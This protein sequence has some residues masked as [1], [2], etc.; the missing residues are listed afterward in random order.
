MHAH[1]WSPHPR[2]L[3]FL[4]S[5]KWLQALCSPLPRFLAALPVPVCW[6]LGACGGGRL[7]STGLSEGPWC[8]VH[9]AHRDSNP[10]PCVT[11]IDKNVLIHSACQGKC[12]K[13]SEQ[14][15][16]CGELLWGRCCLSQTW[17]EARGR[18]GGVRMGAG[19]GAV[20][21]ARSMWRK[22]QMDHY[23]AVV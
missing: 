6:V 13:S 22:C 23:G 5:Q 18:G 8:S 3:P 10:A 21:C 14:G 19:S 16:D 4:L 17:K 1:P 15:V 11:T 2:A 20:E 9:P 12:R 7:G